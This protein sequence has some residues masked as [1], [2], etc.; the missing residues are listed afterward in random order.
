MATSLTGTGISTTV[1]SPMRA[2]KWPTR[3]LALLQ[4][5]IILPVLVSGSVC[6]S[7]DGIEKLEPGLCAC[8][9]LPTCESETVLGVTETAECG[10]CRDEVVTASR[11]T[12]PPS[13]SALMTALPLVTPCVAA[14]APAAVPHS[15]WA[16]E[17]PGKRHPIL[18]C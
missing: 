15:Y 3:F 14:A 7:S 17:P 8:M 18:R 6:I 9:V 12:A 10:P 5:L 1:A 11:S 2:P 4:L 16:G 13:C